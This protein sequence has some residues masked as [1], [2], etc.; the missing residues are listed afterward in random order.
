[1]LQDTAHELSKTAR[2]QGYAIQLDVG[3]KYGPI[4]GNRRLLQYAFTVLGYELMQIPE[5]DIKPV[6]TLASH[7]SKGNIVAGIFTNNAQLTTDAFRRAKAL[8]GSARQTLPQ[9]PASNGAGIFIADSL[10]Q[11]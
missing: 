5:E 7:Q 4:M 11:T 3:G 9:G 2:Q 8:L 1:V 6:I 10:V